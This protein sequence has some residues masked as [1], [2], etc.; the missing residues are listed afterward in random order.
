MGDPTRSDLDALVAEGYDASGVDASDATL[1]VART[2]DPD[3]A[4]RQS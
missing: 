3:L 1:E 2:R 4:G